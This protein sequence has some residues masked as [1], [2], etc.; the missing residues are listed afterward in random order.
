VVKICP[1]ETWKQT[2]TPAALLKTTGGILDASDAAALA[3]LTSRV[4]QGEKTILLDL[5][6]GQS[7]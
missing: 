4:A 6:C 3:A 7:G 2:A 5:H 1:V